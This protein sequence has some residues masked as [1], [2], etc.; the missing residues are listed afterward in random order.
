MLKHLYIKNYALIEELDMDFQ[1]GFSVIT[2]ETGAGNQNNT[3]NDNNQ[4]TGAS[5]DNNLNT[6]TEQNETNS[7]ATGA[8]VTAGAGS[9]HTRNE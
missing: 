2:G 7:D 9:I 5:G 1:E 4:E 6:D 3:P 8:N